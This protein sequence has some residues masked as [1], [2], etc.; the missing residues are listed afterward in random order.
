M[1]MGM[2]VVGRQFRFG[3][4]SVYEKHIYDM[5]AHNSAKAMSSRIKRSLVV[6]CSIFYCL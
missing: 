3:L 5:G 4:I 1:I 6:I 2:A